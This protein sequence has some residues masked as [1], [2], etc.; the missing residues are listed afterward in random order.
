MHLPRTSAKFYQVIVQSAPLYESDTWV[1]SKA[2]MAILKG[3]HI[4]AAYWM[5]KEHVPQRE[6]HRQ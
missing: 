4:C 1:L 6:P 3:F 2:I 5:A